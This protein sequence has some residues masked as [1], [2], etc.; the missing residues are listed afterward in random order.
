MIDEIEI[1]SFAVYCKSKLNLSEAN[2]GDV[3]YYQS[4]PFCIIDAVFSI[5]VRY[6]STQNTVRRFCNY[7]GLN[8][9]SKEILPILD[10]LSVSEF[11]NLHQ[12]FSFEEMANNI[13]QNRQRTSTRNGILKAEAV[14]LFAKILLKFDVNYYQDVNKVLGISLFESEVSKIPGQGRGISTSYFYML[15]GSDD[16]IKPDRMVTRFINPTI[17]RNLSLEEIHDLIIGAQKI[18]IKDFPHLTPKSIDHLIWLYQRAIPIN[19]L[20]SDS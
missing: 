6:S 14:F 19:V 5:G 9:I 11:V 3:Y 1:D 2:L 20:I 18:L 16:Y 12:Q 10:Q 15:D 7:F 4:L 13:Y 17:K 8:E